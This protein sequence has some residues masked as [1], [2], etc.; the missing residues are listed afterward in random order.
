MVSVIIV[1]EFTMTST[2][3]SSVC[4][5]SSSKI[6]P[7]VLTK[8]FIIPLALLVCLF[9]TPPMWL[10]IG[11][12]L[13]QV[14]QSDSCICKFWFILLWFMYSK[15][16]HNSLTAPTKL[17]PLPDLIW[18]MLPLLPINFCNVS[19]KNLYPQKKQLLYK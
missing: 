7:C 16:F 13:I 4:N 15:I 8:P 1:P 14:S 18:Q 11:R 19:K 3:T 2:S 12:F 6:F 10:V 9:Q 17:L 5:D